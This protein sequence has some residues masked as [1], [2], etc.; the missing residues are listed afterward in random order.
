LARKN[1]VASSVR[2]TAVHLIIKEAAMRMLV[3]VKMPHE[4]FNTAVRDGSAA[5]K[6][7]RILDETK[8]EAAYF[9]EFGG[10][11][12]AILIVDVADPSKIPGIAEP[13]FLT[14]NAEVELHAAMSPEDLARAGLDA[15]GKKWS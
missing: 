13:W 8:P 7:K 4:P 6:M 9:T 14:F 15:L 3:Q 5:Q 1:G 11:R 10:L 2:G 12:T